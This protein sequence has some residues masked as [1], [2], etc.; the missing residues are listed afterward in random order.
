LGNYYL[1]WFL[2]E[3]YNCFQSGQFRCHPPQTVAIQ[4]YNLLQCV[5]VDNTSLTLGLEITPFSNY[6]N[7]CQI[8]A[9]YKYC[10]SIILLW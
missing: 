6:L 2:A 8:T 3:A 7:N 10:N 4:W 5:L 9:D 1:L